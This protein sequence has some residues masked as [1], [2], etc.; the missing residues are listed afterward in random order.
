MKNALIILGDTLPLLRGLPREELGELIEA[1]IDH[2][3]GNGEEKDFESGRA[4]IMY[5]FLVNQIDEMARR[6]A[7]KER[8]VKLDRIETR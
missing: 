2:V 3:L 1:L 7:K 6:K 4:A 5:P 8:P